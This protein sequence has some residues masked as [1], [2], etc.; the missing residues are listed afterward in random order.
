M[1]LDINASPTAIREAIERK[2]FETLTKITI[3][4]DGE[5][6]IGAQSFRV[7]NDNGII[8]DSGKIKF[9][10]S[11]NTFEQSATLTL[12]SKDRDAIL[13]AISGDGKC[14]FVFLGSENQSRTVKMDQELRERFK[15]MKELVQ[16]IEQEIEP[17][18]RP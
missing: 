4:T 14:E 15:H 18:Q 11:K 6:P 16:V 12:A 7:L 1:W 2:K 3:S 13:D 5:F 9:T 8:F 10:E 17:K